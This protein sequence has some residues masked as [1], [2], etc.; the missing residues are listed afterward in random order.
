[1]LNGERKL[2]IL[3]ILLV[4][5]L[6]CVKI[7]CTTGIHIPNFTTRIPLA[8]GHFEVMNSIIKIT[9]LPFLFPKQEL[10]H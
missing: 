5:T 7:Q 2:P 8:L 1:M 3:I 6:L 9:R 10:E 4:V